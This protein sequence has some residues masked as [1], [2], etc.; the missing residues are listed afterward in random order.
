MVQLPLVWGQLLLIW[1]KGVVYMDW[2]ATVRVNVLRG[3]DS[4]LEDDGAPI[5]AALD[6]SDALCAPFLVSVVALR[7]A[8]VALLPVMAL[9]G[10]PVVVLR[11]APAVA[12]V[13]VVTLLGA[14]VVASSGVLFL[15]VDVVV[16][17]AAVAF[18]PLAALTVASVVVHLDG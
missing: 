15:N 10:A 18:A 1:G 7:N 17:A 2:C 8:H 13:P 5:L 3:H 6:V 4:R 16:P 14:P 9:L 12:L 11:N